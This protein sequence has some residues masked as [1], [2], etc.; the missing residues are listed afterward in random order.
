MDR[1]GVLGLGV[2]GCAAALAGCVGRGTPQPGTPITILLNPM[3][4]AYL[5][6]FHAIDQGFFAAEGLK[7]QTKLYTGS[8]NAQLPLLA[9]GDVDV[10]GVIAAPALFNQAAAGF[11]IRLLCALT[12]PR[13]GYLDGV[14]LLVRQDVWD[15]APFRS[16]ADLRGRTV[17]GA[18]EGNPIDMLIRFALL[19]AHLTTD[20]VALS[21]KIRSPSDVPY[22]FNEKQVEL[23]GVSEPTAT[24]IQQRGLARKWLGYSQVVPWFQDTFLGASE[25]FVRYRGDEVKALVR[26]Y[27]RAAH[28]IDEHRGAWSPRLLATSAKWTRLKAEDISAT[29]RLPYWSPTGSVDVGALQRVQNF[30]FDRRLVRDRTDVGRLAGRDEHAAGTAIRGTV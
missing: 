30:W 1:R 18:A 2:A 12:E 5:P 9:R 6:I 14:N 29:G 22:L 16:V 28:E 13:Q 21:Y 23:A 3:Q 15:R 26:A 10:A 20:Q 4:M 17:D 25:D 8:A 27:L 7:I 11:G 19:E 24:F